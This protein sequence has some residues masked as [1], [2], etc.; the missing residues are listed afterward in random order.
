MDTSD[1]D[2]VFDE[3]G[4]C[5]HCHSYTARVGSR[6]YSPGERDEKLKQMVSRIKAAGKHSEYDCIIGVSGGVDS[7]YVAYLAKKV[8]LNPLAVHF[9][10][11]WNSEL[12]VSNIEKVLNRLEIDLYTFVIDWEEFRDLQKSFLYASTPDGEIPTDHAINALLFRE[13]SKRNIRYIITGM[14]FATESI[15]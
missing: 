14:N 15:A 12:A 3:E 6:I 1:K 4:V 11:G 9:D 13:A 8:G 10:N 7:T 2:I 5:S